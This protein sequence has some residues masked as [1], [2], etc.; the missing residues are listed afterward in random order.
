MDILGGFVD[1]LI[2]G[3]YKY[4]IKEN[5]AVIHSYIGKDHSIILP[6]Q[7]DG[8]MVKEIYSHA[9][10]FKQLKS[11]IIP[12]TVSEI[13]CEA[14]AQ[15]NIRSLIIPN[16]VIEIGEGAFKANK[17]NYVL[18][19]DSI[20]IIGD[21]AFE[22]NKLHYIIIP[23]SVKEIRDFAF[24][25]NFLFK[26]VMRSHQTIVSAKAFPKSI[27]KPQVSKD[28][29]IDIPRINALWKNFKDFNT[30]M[31]GTVLIISYLMEDGFFKVLSSFAILYA[32][33]TGISF[34]I[35]I[36]AFMYHLLKDR[37]KKP[38]R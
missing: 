29:K 13:G 30:N 4:V 14:F 31:I 16:S 35:F 20:E 21:K 10:K 5:K 19:S 25:G 1:T 22:D 7:I 36:L 28:K 17:L 8:Y 18:F 38:L 15:N 33:L 26:I 2:K 24:K 6:S 27:F 37:I 3:D 32:I 11:V 12:N 23:E 34:T 9:F